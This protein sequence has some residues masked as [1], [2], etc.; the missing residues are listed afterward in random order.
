MRLA[1]FHVENF[2]SIGPSGCLIRIDRIVVLI[3]R[4]NAG[5]STILDAYE[6]LAS[7]GKELGLSHFH[8]QDPSV[9]IVITGY[10]DQVTPEDEERIGRGWQ[11][12]HPEFGT[13]IAFRYVWRAP[14]ERARKQSYNPGLGD[15]DDGGLGGFDSMIM[16][17]IPQPVR[18]RPTDPTDTTQARLLAM[19]KEH[20]KLSLKADAGQT[21]AAFDQIEQLAREIFD[22]TRQSFD[23]LSARITRQVGEVF[24]GT[25]IE[26]IP[27][28]K[29]A[30]DEKLI[31]AD[32]YLQVTHGGTSPL[33]L[34][35]TGL[36][37]ALLW[38]TLSV[39][40]SGGARRK[41]L[42]PDAPRILLIDEPEAF[43]HPPTIRAARD[44]LYAFALQNPDWQVIATTHSPIFIDLSKD[45]TT[46]I[47][48]D[49][50]PGAARHAVST[51]KVSFDAQERERL[52]MIRACNPVVNEFFFH[53]D[54]VLVE[55]ATEQIALLHVARGM[56]R[57]VHVINCL[58]K[59]NLPMFARIL[60]HFRVPYA[61]LH[62]ADTRFVRGA[63]GYQ[64][65]AM[66]T[67]NACIRVAVS[68]AAIGRIHVQFPHF[69]GEY[70]GEAMKAGKVDRVLRALDDPDSEDFQ[71]IVAALVPI[72]AG[73]AAGQTTQPAF[74]RKLDA[75]LT[76]R[77]SPGDPLWYQPDL[78]AAELDEAGG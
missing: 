42:E 23:E 45:H 27:R 51:D 17:R 56:G 9:P 28:S 18:I 31:A 78:Q 15:F 63:K 21:Q 8:N 68:A 4:N 59:A 53:D 29:D 76:Q 19:L 30:L 22:S 39:M 37:R 44:A 47:R 46:I 58:G 74:D 60:N 7:S 25:T 10:F 69:E 77:V 49:N 70:F 52:K 1:G 35:G 71:R 26:L 61:V 38:S 32:S 40:S 24:P 50:A 57:E 2:K 72:L 16:S 54:I 12:P 34:Q 33:E 3:G 36:Q 14:D 75:Y 6:A 13:C 64:R 5:K 11:Y 73:E 67:M 55:G 48:V 65:N 41:A 20:V 66:W 62:D 43:L